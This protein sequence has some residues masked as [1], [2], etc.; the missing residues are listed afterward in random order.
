MLIMIARAVDEVVA[1]GQFLAGAKREG[2]PFWRVL[3][4]GGTIDWY[5]TGP[6]CGVGRN[7]ALAATIDGGTLMAGTRP[8]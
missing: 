1:M 2:Q 6:P 8:R 7:R 5:T 3:W 4:V